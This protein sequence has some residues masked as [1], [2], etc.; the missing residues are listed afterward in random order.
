M[1]KQF[2]MV[3]GREALFRV[4]VLCITDTNIGCSIGGLTVYIR[5][6]ADDMVRWAP[7]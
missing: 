4:Y 3:Y 1:L 2:L 7:S 6:F 5:C